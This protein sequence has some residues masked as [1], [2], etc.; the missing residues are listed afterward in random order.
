MC[1]AGEAA[2]RAQELP[3][4]GAG[5]AGDTL[6]ALA[7]RLRDGE[8]GAFADLMTRTQARLLG[9]AWRILGD[10]ELARDAAQE[11]YLRI[12]R[13]LHAYRPSEPFEPWMV[14]IAVHACYDL[15]RKRG[16][17]PLPE[18]DLEGHE[19][20]R[21]EPRL[22]EQLLRDQRRRLVQR[23]LR[24]LPQAERTALVL[25]DLEGF[26]TEAVAR[27]L[28]VQPV[29]IRSQVASARAKLQAACARLLEPAPGGHP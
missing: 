15:A 6:D 12:H 4:A 26:P 13:S 20:L 8:A 2:L 23:A 18:A 16:P 11:I 3:L 21:E 25:R 22:D 14:R 9:L 27:L 29:T 7:R 19:A 10:R 24:D 5:L 17:L 28:G 1:W